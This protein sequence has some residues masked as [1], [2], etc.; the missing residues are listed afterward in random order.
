SIYHVYNRACLVPGTER[1]TVTKSSAIYHY[2][3]FYYDQ[4]GRLTKTIPPAAVNI[5]TDFTRMDAVPLIFSPHNNALSTTYTYNSLGGKLTKITPDG[6]ITK[7][8]YDVLGRP[9]ASQDAVQATDNTH[10]YMLYDKIGRVTESGIIKRGV[11]SF[12]T[13]LSNGKMQ[14]KAFNDAVEA[15][16]NDKQEIN[17]VYYDIPAFVINVA[18]EFSTNR[19]I[20][21]RNRVASVAYFANGAALSSNNYQH[22]MHYSYNIVGHLTEIVQ[23]FKEIATLSGLPASVAANHRFKKIR[24]KFDLLTGK[25]KEEYYQPGRADQFYHWNKYDADNRLISVSTGRSRYEPAD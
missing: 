14:Y 23:D 25:I 11:T 8:V 17:K 22:A 6:G 2:T 3:L 4:S 15:K 9:L 16:R 13:W 18:Q 7:W 5:Q 10:S 1:L 20:N 21:L 19:Q 24:Y 12:S